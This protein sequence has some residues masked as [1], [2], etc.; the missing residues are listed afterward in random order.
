MS[1][2]LAQRCTGCRG[3]SDRQGL[4]LPGARDLPGRGGGGGEQVARG[5]ERAERQRK[6]PL[7]GD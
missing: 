7:R 2:A 4:C 6:G 1:Q 5:A 3:G